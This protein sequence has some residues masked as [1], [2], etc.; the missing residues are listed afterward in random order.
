MKNQA[1]PTL[2]LA[3]ILQATR[4]TCILLMEWL[5]I[6]VA[7][8]PVADGSIHEEAVETAAVINTM[9]RNREYYEQG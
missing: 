1:I 7:V 6:S 5:P 3:I 4:L 8:Q 9:K 2:L